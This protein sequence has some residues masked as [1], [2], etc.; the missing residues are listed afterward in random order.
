MLMTNG[1][2]K[3]ISYVS[4]FPHCTMMLGGEGCYADTLGLIIRDLRL[5][6]HE[7]NIFGYTGSPVMK[8]LS[9]ESDHAFLMFDNDANKKESDKTDQADTGSSQDGDDDNQSG[10]TGDDSSPS[11]AKQDPNPSQASTLEMG[12]AASQGLIC[13]ASSS[14]LPGN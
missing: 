2:N 6:L 9:K 4:K 12:V 10:G 13:I 14:I 5:L 1:V 11:T 7:T 8:K 3:I